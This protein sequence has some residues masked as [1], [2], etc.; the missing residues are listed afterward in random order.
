VQGSL[1]H[2]HAPEFMFD[3]FCR[4]RLGAGGVQVF[5]TMP[6]GAPFDSIIQ[7]AMPH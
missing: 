4:S 7:R 1:L 5:G 6:A 3:A 2:R